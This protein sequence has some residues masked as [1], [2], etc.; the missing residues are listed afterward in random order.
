ME[1]ATIFFAVTALGWTIFSALMNLI[2]KSNTAEHMLWGIHKDA[3]DISVE[4]RRA[5]FNHLLIYQVALAVV[6]FLCGGILLAV[7]IGGVW[8]PLSTIPQ[9]FSGLLW[10]VLSSLGCILIV[11]GIFPTLRV[12]KCLADKAGEFDKLLKIAESNSSKTQK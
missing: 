3:K 9:Y 11:G 2:D 8:H 7:G 10:I 1:F 5:L 12:W 4:Q 6:Q